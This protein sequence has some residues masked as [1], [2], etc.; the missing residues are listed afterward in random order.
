M[1]RSNNPILTQNLTTGGHQI[2]RMRFMII[3]SLDF[4]HFGDAIF[5]KF[6]EV[7]IKY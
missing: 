6:E 4:R 3:S 2:S 1:M 7:I 5:E